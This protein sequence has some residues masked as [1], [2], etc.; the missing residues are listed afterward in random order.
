MDISGSPR[1]ADSAY[2][3]I[4]RAI[5]VGDLREGQELS[6][7]ELTARFGFGRTPTREALLRLT[8]EGFVSW[9]PRQAPV[10][11]AAAPDRLQMCYEARLAIERSVVPYAI[12]RLNATDLTELERLAHLLGECVQRGDN[13]AAAET[14]YL[15][16]AGVMGASRNTFMYDASIV[17]YNTMLASWYRAYTLL[18][19][20]SCVGE[21]LELVE[22]L[23]T[24]DPGVAV[25]A[26]SNHVKGAYERQLKIFQS[27]LEPMPDRSLSQ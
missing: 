25:E 19:M 9:E 1:K 22:A 10:V 8:R 11:S 16:H 20:R 27:S 21:H 5:I 15:F 17:I 26:L 13:Y 18:D 3:A 23:K 24:R 4:R 12:A 6:E 2:I 7:A 14:D